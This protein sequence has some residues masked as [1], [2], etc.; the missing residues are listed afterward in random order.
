MYAVQWF[1]VCRWVLLS[2]SG[3]ADSVASILIVISILYSS[4]NHITV[5]MELTVNDSLDEVNFSYPVIES[6]S[7]IQNNLLLLLVYLIG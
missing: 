5:N 6:T 3:N 4:L 2:L 1:C 7:L